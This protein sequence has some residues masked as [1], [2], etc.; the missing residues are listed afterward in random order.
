MSFKDPLLSIRPSCCQC[1]L[2]LF[3]DFSLYK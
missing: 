2:V 3:W 1:V